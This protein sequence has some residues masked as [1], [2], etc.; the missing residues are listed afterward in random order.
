MPSLDYTHS[1]SHGD[2]WTGVSVPSGPH[3]DPG[4]HS[5]HPLKE[6]TP[7]LDSVT[8]HDLSPGCPCPHPH[9]SPLT[10]FFVGENLSLLHEPTLPRRPIPASETPIF[11]PI[12]A[13][14]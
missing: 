4:H 1:S 2:T 14:D 6:P 13:G 7:P 12:K 3:M 8:G 9:P 10:L 11:K 5:P